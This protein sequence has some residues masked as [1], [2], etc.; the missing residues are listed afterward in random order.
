[1]LSVSFF[2][3]AGPLVV[4]KHRIRLLLPKVTKTLQLSFK[5]GNYPKTFLGISTLTNIYSRQ[6]K[7]LLTG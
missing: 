5:C 4:V 3:M 7:K 6:P 2:L 1:M